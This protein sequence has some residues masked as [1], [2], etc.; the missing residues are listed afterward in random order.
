MGGVATTAAGWG[1]AAALAPETAGASVVIAGISTAIGAIIGANQ[2]AAENEK[3]A[4][5][6]VIMMQILEL[7][8]M[9]LPPEY[10]R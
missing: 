6:R 2:D 1:T 4:A 5:T 7:L 3:N 10:E 9:V 8:R